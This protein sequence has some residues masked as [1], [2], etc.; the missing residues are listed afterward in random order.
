LK[1]FQKANRLLFRVCMKSKFFAIDW[2]LLLPS[3][4]LLLIS[5]VTLSSIQADLFRNQ[6]FSI[7]VALAFFLFFSQTHYETLKSLS[8]P[9]YILSLVVLTIVLIIGFEARGAV[10]WVE[11]F[12]ISIQFSEF[13]KPLLAISFATFLS[14]QSNK[15]A[16]TYLISLALLLPIML[17]IFFQ[18]DLGNALIYGFVALFTLFVYG[19]P[20]L[21]F[22][23]SA[24]PLILVSPILWTFLHDYQRQRVLTFFSPTND[25]LGTSYNVIQAIIAVGSG[26]MFGKGLSEGT[27]S[28]LKFLP[29]RHT[30][31]IFATAT[32]GLGFIG[33]LII[34]GL[35]A[36]LLWRIFWIY[37]QTNEMF[38]KLFAVTAFLLIFIH[39][40]VNIG[41]NIGIVPVVGVTLPF[42]SYGGSSL[43]SN[44]ILLGI[45]SSLST[46]RRSAE[47]LEIH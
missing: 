21:W 40:F 9:M 46:S 5:L 3:L 30:D 4:I 47:V 26:S 36:L 13:F 29:E 10:R 34:V 7:G 28:A 25:P 42:V 23:I 38:G 41:M 16:R 33:G 32:E 22:I 45:L 2:W 31:F 27:Q 14:S 12:G 8:L 20:I 35:F 11:V 6:L 24:V 1:R 44:F 39:F 15:S 19:I 37:Q 17:I 43:V 18:P